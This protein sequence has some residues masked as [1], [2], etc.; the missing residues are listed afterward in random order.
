LAPN[1]FWLAF[2]SSG[3]HTIRTIHD[4]SR[5]V[6]QQHYIYDNMHFASPPLQQQQATAA[7]LGPQ[8]FG[9]VV[10]GWPV[11]TDFHP[12]DPTGRKF[13]LRLY[14]PGD[15]PAPISSV[16]ELTVF[17]LAPIPLDH[18]A[19][20]YWQIEAAGTGTNATATG[21]ELLGSITADRPSSVF[22]TGWSE[23]EQL[24]EIAS[25]QSVV[26]TIGVSLEP[27]AN[28]Q[29]L[30]SSLRDHQQTKLFV[31]QRVALDLFNFMASFDAGTGGNQHMVV[32]KNI[33]DRWFQRFEN[34]FRRDPTFFLR[35][36]DS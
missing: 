16:S 1:F 19:L 2:F 33:F 12:V 26:V 29:N 17:A 23:H 8:T 32:P 7:P 6:K 28:V 30:T 13:V 10:S 20:V 22:Q 25:A 4:G 27:L 14:C 34:R 21:F 15:L 24:L 5:T 9:L 11:R 35:N 18:G 3:R 31:A 36:K